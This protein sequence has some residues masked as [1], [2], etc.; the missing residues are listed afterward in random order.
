MTDLALIPEAD[1]LLT[2]KQ[3]ADWLGI[4]VKTVLVWTLAGDL[5]GAIEISRGARTTRRWRHPTIKR[6][7]KD[8]EAG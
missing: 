8:R 5:P 4:T 2:S 6:F 7:L 3:V 1:R